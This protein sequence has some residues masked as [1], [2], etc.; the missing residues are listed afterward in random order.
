MDGCEI[1]WAVPPSPVKFS[2]KIPL[3]SGIPWTDVQSLDWNKPGT[4]GYSFLLFGES[5]VQC[6]FHH[7]H[8]PPVPYQKYTTGEP[9]DLL[10]LHFP[11]NLD[12]RVS[13]L[14]IRQ[15]PERTTTLIV[16]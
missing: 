5:V 7:V 16:S 3:V 6:N 14:W 15:Y 2:P 11:M 4:S 8:G 13:E 12:E 9:N 10:C 1:R